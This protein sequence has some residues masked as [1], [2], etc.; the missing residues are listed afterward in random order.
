MRKPRKKINKN[1][2][3][4]KVDYGLI[5]QDYFDGIPDWIKQMSPDELVKS[6]EEDMELYP[7]LISKEDILRP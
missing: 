3:K 7:P 2:Y 1:K 6:L 4:N 5:G